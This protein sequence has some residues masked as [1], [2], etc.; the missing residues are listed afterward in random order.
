MGGHRIDGGV[1]YLGNFPFFQSS[2]FDYFGDNTLSKFLSRLSD[3]YL[4]IFNPNSSNNCSNDLPTSLV[5]RDS[6]KL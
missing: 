4:L 3:L 2:C 5:N 6:I 1:K